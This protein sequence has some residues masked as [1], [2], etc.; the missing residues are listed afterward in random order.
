MN[1]DIE[2]LVKKAKE[3]DL[4]AKEELL[5][6][7]KPYVIKKARGIY[8]KNYDMDDLIQIGNISI[9]KAIDKYNLEKENFVSYVTLAINNN[10]NYE[11]RKMSKSRYDSS[12]NK[13]VEGDLEIIDIILEEENIEEDFIKKEKLNTVYIALNKLN[14]KERKLIY[15]IYFKDIK[16]KEYALKEEIKYGTVLKRKTKILKKLREFLKEK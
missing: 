16:L 9:M 13:V 5:N 12:L 2:L 10:F 7:F 8:I 3:S 4:K 6:R 1:K 15:S 14:E 11:I